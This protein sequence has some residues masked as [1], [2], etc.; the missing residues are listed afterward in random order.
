MK[1]FSLTILIIEL[2]MLIWEVKKNYDMA[3]LGIGMKKLTE[4]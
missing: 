2:M 4:E 3:K 1:L